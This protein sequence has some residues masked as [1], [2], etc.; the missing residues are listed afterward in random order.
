[1]AAAGAKAGV[2]SS[3][4]KAVVDG[5]TSIIW[6]NIEVLKSES[7]PMDGA[8]PRPAMP[9][10]DKVGPVAAGGKL[11]AAL[12]PLVKGQINTD[13]PFKIIKKAAE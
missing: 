5:L 2:Y 11:P 9:Q 7:R 4:S 3:S 8:T 12:E 13:K 6:P 1:M 10:T